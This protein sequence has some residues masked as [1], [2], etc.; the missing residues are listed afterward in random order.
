[1]K[2]GALRN[3]NPTRKG[4]D[5]CRACGSRDYLSL[6]HIIPRSICPPEARTDLRNGVTLCSACHELWHAGVP[7]S[8]S[9]LAVEEWEY[10]SSL[11][12]TG[13]E[14]AYYLDKHY[15]EKRAA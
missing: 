14:V 7:M 8:R 4:E 15:P 10:V 6:H 9:L 2:R 12:L 1:M 3:W 13:R 11:E 5:R